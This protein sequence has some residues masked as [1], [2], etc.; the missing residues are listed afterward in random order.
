MI[1]ALLLAIPLS[2]STE[3]VLAQT[4]AKHQAGPYEDAVAPAASAMPRTVDGHPDFSG[5]WST[6]FITSTGRLPGAKSVTVSDAEARQISKGF[7]DFANSP[8]AG[9]LVD[10]DFYVAGVDQ[11]LRVNGEWRTSL[12]TSPSTG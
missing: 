6:A 2:F 11:L 10:P 1:R 8:A 3:A 4:P 9:T 5:Q 7:V 12:I